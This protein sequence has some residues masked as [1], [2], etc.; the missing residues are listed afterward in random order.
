GALVV[1]ITPAGARLT[2]DGELQPVD[3]GTWRAQLAGRHRVV[4]SAPGRKTLELDVEVEPGAI[5]DLPL[6][7]APIAPPRRAPAT[8]AAARVRPAAAPPT[9]A[10]GRRSPYCWGD[11]RAPPRRHRPRPANLARARL[12][13]GAGRPGPN[14]PGPAAHAGGRAPRRPGQGPGGR[15]PPP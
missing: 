2:V 6:E 11:P 14:R 3:A 4:A 9:L 13:R 7:L 12:P 1:H 15:P 10:R 8:P 5:I